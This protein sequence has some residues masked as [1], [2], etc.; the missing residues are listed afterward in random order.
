[1]GANR[2]QIE[3]FIANLANSPEPER[4]IDVANQ[5]A[6]LSRSESIPLE[7]LEEHVKQK[8][9]EKQMLED[10]IKQRRAILE[11]TDVEI[12]TIKEYKELKSELSKYHLSSEDPAKLLTLLNN[13]KRYGYDPK[14]VVAEFSNIKSLRRREKAL[15]DNSKRL[16]ERMA[17]CQSVLPLCEQIFQIRIG[18]SE[19]LA[20]HT[21]VSEKAEMQNLSMES[22]AYRVIE[23]I[24]DYEQLGGMKKQQSDVS[25]QIYTLNQLS[26][27]QNK[28]IMALFKL[29][30]LGVTDDQILNMCRFF[31]E[32]GRGMAFGSNQVQNM[33]HFQA[34]R[35]PTA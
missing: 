30:S 25:M 28:A 6:H 3:S 21:A 22:A 35:S 33:Y 15:Q 9:E 16:E 24:Q 12:Q 31:E 32:Y 26:G 2:D 7:H 17:K 19:L 4:L 10:E 27:R 34:N 20:F 8:E 29:Q 14:K 18:I 11:S 13:I 1:M 23:D 5:V